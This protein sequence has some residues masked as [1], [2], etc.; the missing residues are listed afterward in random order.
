M[1]ERHARRMLTHLSKE[2]PDESKAA[3]P[4]TA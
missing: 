1:T 4:P 3:I 2:G